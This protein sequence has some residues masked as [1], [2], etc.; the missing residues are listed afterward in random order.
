M[1]KN[2]VLYH[3]QAEVDVFAKAPDFKSR[4]IETTLDQILEAYNEFI[5]DQQLELQE[6]Y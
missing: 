2:A 4:I 6:A 5:Q 1:T 3:N